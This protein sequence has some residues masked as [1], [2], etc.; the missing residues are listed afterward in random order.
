VP[1][2]SVRLLNRSDE[3]LSLADDLGQPLPRWLV[4]LCGT[5]EATACG[6]PAEAEQ[7]AGEF[8]AFA[9]ETGQPAPRRSTS[10]PGR[11]P[12]CL[13]RISGISPDSITEFPQF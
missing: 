8:L 4:M 6:M 7:R 10:P 9:P 1:G 13:T 11:H 2:E 12:L 5:T 3:L